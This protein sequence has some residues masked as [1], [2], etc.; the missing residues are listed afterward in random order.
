MSLFAM[1][2]GLFASLT[3]FVSDAFAQAAPAAAPGGAAAPGVEAV[4]MQFLPLFLIFAVFYFLLIRPQ[5]KKFEQHKAMVEALRRGD[6]VITGGGIIGTIH[7]VEGEEVWVEIADNVRV[8]VV[9]G[10]ITQVSAKTEAVADAAEKPT[11]KKDAS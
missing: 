5:Q 1:P 6:K 2:L 11:D 10:T 9:K 7:K 3:L 8:R 4:I